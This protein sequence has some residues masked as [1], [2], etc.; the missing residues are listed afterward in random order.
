MILLDRKDNFS[1]SRKIEFVYK[2]KRLCC[3]NSIYKRFQELRD[4]LAINQLILTE[5]TLALV[6]R[7]LP[8]FFLAI[9]KQTI[10]LKP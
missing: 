8:C 3:L 2:Y 7:H 9:Y 6:M 5:V 1:K 4:F 10:A